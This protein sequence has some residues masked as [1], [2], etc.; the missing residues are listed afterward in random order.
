MAAKIKRDDFVLVI[1]GKDRGRRG[2]VIR[3]IPKESRVVVEGVNIVKK[4]QRPAPTKPGGIVEMPAPIHVSNVMLVCPRCNRPTRVG[5]GFLE[6]GK[7]VRVCK[8]CGENIDK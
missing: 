8:K 6:D 4:H 3:V 7:K 1:A 5:F 2:K